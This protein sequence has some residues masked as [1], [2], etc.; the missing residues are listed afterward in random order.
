MPAFQASQIIQCPAASLRQFLGCPANLPLVSDPEL[1]LEIISAPPL[2]TAGERIEFRIMA[3]GF[4]QRAIHIYQNVTDDEISEHQLEG[5]L[6]S[7]THRQLFTSL[8][9]S[10]CVLEDSIEFTPPGGMLGFMMTESRILESLEQGMNERYSAITELV[11]S[12]RIR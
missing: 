6:R 8:N 5:P 1:Q 10:E 11:R 4:R 2:V 3:Y 7:W 9:D 12:G